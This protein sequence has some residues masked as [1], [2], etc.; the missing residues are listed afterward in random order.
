MEY[1]GV[2]VGGEGQRLVKDE[3]GSSLVEL[4]NNF[5]SEVKRYEFHFHEK[6]LNRRLSRSDY[7]SCHM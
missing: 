3:A 2:W 4:D 1:S 7:V 6:F 5:E